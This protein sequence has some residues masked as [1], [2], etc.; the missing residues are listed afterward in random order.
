[1]LNSIIHPSKSLTDR[2][3]ILCHKSTSPQYCGLSLSIWYSVMQNRY[4][5]RNIHPFFSSVQWAVVCHSNI[6]A[7]QYMMLMDWLVFCLSFVAASV[8]ASTSISWEAHLRQLSSYERN[9]FGQQ[10]SSYVPQGTLLV[11]L[12]CVATLFSRPIEQSGDLNKAYHIYIT[13]DQSSI[14]IGAPWMFAPSLDRGDPVTQLA[15]V[16]FEPRTQP[17]VA[18]WLT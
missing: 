6:Y 11:T 12:L 13:K 3:F 4:L 5:T 14:M 8:S 1:M 2:I 7:V 15:R 18:W 9:T 10:K 16:G 17:L